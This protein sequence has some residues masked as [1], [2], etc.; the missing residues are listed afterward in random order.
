MP[1]HAR[2]AELRRELV[3]LA[4]HDLYSSSDFAES[5]V[6]HLVRGTLTP[7]NHDVD[8]ILGSKR[9]EVKLSSSRLER[10]GHHKFQFRRLWGDPNKKRKN[11]D[12]FVLV[13]LHEDRLLFYVVS[14]PLMKRRVK[15]DCEPTVSAPCPR[16]DP[17]LVD[18]EDLPVAVEQALTN[19]YDYP[20][21]SRNRFSEERQ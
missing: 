5:Y 8:C 11:V 19:P 15:R 10:R 4:G 9:I 1:I 14:E 6:C 18:A 16:W 21:L 13:G 17:F 20:G 2:L 3:A 7:P 12:V